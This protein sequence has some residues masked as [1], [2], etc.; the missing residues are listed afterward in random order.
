MYV[1]PAREGNVGVAGLVLCLVFFGP[2]DSDADGQL[3]RMR[4]RQ[5]IHTLHGIDKAGGCN[6]LVYGK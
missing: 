2:E 1:N 4:G 3:T 6:G 5:G